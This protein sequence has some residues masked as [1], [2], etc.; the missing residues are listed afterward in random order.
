MAFSVND[1][2]LFFIFEFQSHTN[3][4]TF[5]LLHQN[6]KKHV[7]SPLASGA[8]ILLTIYTNN[9]LHRIYL[10]EHMLDKPGA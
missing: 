3:L 4:L 8:A 10:K 7:L 1:S 9:S 6:G 2:H 5:L